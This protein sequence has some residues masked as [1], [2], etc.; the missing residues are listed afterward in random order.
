MS[1]KSRRRKEHPVEAVI[2]GSAEVEALRQRRLA[3]E[4]LESRKADPERVRRILADIEER[5]RLHTATSLSGFVPSPN[6]QKPLGVSDGTGVRLQL[7]RLDRNTFKTH[8][9]RL[10]RLLILVLV[11]VAAVAF[12]LMTVCFRVEMFASVLVQRIRMR[13]KT[14]SKTTTMTSTF[15][16]GSTDEEAKGQT[17]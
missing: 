14:T 12:R 7:E 10:S 6:D 2:N 1:L 4:E 15:T 3:L 11:A 16:T 8:T 9:D 13:S 17:H 5:K